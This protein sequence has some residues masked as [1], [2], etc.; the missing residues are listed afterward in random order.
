MPR[1][2]SNETFI[3]ILKQT[4]K[5]LAI[6]QYIN[7]ECLSGKIQEEKGKQT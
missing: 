7:G 1:G 5:T 4:G 6:T 3:A 2:Q